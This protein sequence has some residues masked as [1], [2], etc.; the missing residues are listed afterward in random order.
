MSRE[1]GGTCI[2]PWD[3][4][5]AASLARVGER[6]D[7]VNALLYGAPLGQ[8]P[9]PELAAPGEVA[10]SIPAG[11]PSRPVGQLVDRR[12]LEPRVGGSS[13]SGAAT[14]FDGSEEPW[15]TGPLAQPGERLPCKQEVEGSIPSRSTVYAEASGLDPW[16]D[17]PVAQLAERRPCKPD[18]AGSI[19][20][21][22]SINPARRTLDDLLVPILS[23]LLKGDI[24]ARLALFDIVA[25]EVE[26]YG[27]TAEELR[28]ALDAVLAAHPEAAGVYE[29]VRLG[30]HPGR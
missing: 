30:I 13:P 2:D 12:P 23:P 11:A 4:P 26:E 18:V 17:G 19:P 15:I 3:G 21:G 10:G 5:V 8:A 24:W 9:G 7:Q 6:L 14:C 29:V 27:G 22:P 20:A 16:E 1:P 28:T 25:A